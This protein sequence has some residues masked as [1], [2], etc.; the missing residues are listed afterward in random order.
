MKKRAVILGGG[1]GGLSCAL[2][3]K[4]YFQDEME[5]IVMDRKEE[6]TPGAYFLWVMLGKVKAEKVKTNIQALKTVG[7][8]FMRGEILKIDPWNC[9]VVSTSLSLPADYLVIALGADVDYQNLPRDAS[10]FYTLAD[11]EKAH[12][13]ISTFQKGECVLLIPST[14]YKCPAAPYEAMFLL[15]GYFRRKGVRQ[16]ISLN[17]YT[18]EPY[19]LPTAGQWIGENVRK[20][21]A[22]RKINFYPNKIY[23]GYSEEKK[24]LRFSDGSVA[25]YDLLLVVPHHR[26]A[27]VLRFSEIA[28]EKGWVT[29]DPKTLRTRWEKVYAVGDCCQ[30]PLPGT[31]Q[32]DQ[33][34]FLPK[35][36]IFA[37]SQG[38]VVAQEIY[39]DVHPL[40]QFFSFDGKGYCY[41]DTGN[42]RAAFLQADFFSPSSP[43]VSYRPPSIWNYRR[44]MKEV[45]K[46]LHLGFL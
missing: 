33:T 29:A 13:K 40:R 32:P 6:F 23:V 18:V 11:A 17:I 34:L 19:P 39:R 10:S 3:L 41:L 15:D 44:K 43:R 16:K 30:F 4:Q 7:I 25:H 36:G 8:E 27:G 9:Q 28:P 46:F 12:A 26:P 37:L 14:P 1:F 5:I 2:H 24:E 42:G 35:A 21:L 45:Q 38:K 22:K 20:L 31:Y